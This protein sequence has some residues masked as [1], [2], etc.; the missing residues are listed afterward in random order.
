MSELVP[1]EVAEELAGRVGLGMPQT[2]EPL[3]GGRNNRVYR[4]DLAGGKTALLKCYHTDLRDPRDRLNAEWNFLNYAGARGVRNVPQPL[5]KDPARHSALYSFVIGERP[6]SINGD[7]VRQAAEFA[8]GINQAPDEAEHLAPASEAC[9]SLGSHLETVDRRIAR[10]QELDARVPYVGE[11]RA[12][13]E[14]RLIAMWGDI[15]SRVIR[16]AEK[17]GV[18]L[19][20]TIRGIV[21]PSDFGFHNALV[22]SNGR[23]TFIDFEYAGRDDPAKL[24][25]DF[26]C[27]PEFSIPLSHYSDFTGHLASLLGL[28]EEDL[29]RAQVLL[30]AWNRTRHGERERQNYRRFRSQTPI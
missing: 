9:F 18:A 26:F 21:S 10:L 24:I 6:K 29:W 11:V 22:D 27:Q 30:N 2:V 14:N 5:A 25:C 3:A 7:L 15:K 8:L 19:T 17:R 20:N 23:A 16:Q 4:V 1:Q 28:R 12:F 13:V